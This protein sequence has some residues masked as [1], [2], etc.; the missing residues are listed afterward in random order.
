MNL[1][2]KEGVFS[3][4]PLEQITDL[5]G[6]AV[7]VDEFS[8]MPNCPGIYIVNNGHAELQADNILY[9]GMAS[10]SV[11]QRWRNHHKL[12]AL[13]LLERLKIKLSVFI[14]P[15]PPG[16]FD[17]KTIKAWEKELIKRF[18]PP[19]NNNSLLCDYREV[20]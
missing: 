5:F 3:S 10:K 7:G 2:I 13:H 15:F 17:E 18:N 11:K 20:G 16:L 8:D 9:I 6:W 1:E 4:M 12:P 19:L 14:Y